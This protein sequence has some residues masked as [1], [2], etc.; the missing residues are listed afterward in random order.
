MEPT[1]SL[2]DLLETARLAFYWTSFDPDG[3]G[4][5]TITEFE[6]QLN[7]DLTTI[8]KEAANSEK[9]GDILTDVNERYI[10]NY[11]KYFTAWLRSE[12]NCASSA[13]A[14]PANFPVKRMEKHR[15][16]ADAKFQQFQDW[17]RRA[18]KAI[19]K[20]VKVVLTPGTELAKAEAKLK[21]KLQRQAMMK[22]ANKEIRKYK[23]AKE[24]PS[25]LVAALQALCVC[26]EEINELLGE[27]YQNRLG[28]ATWELSYINENIHR[29][30]KRVLYLRDK[31]ANATGATIQEYTTFKVVENRELDRVQFMFPGDPG[32][33]IRVLLRKKG[34]IYSPKNKANQR[35]L[36]PNA[37]RD[38][39]ELARKINAMLSPTV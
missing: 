11:R 22:A 10:M 29:L 32:D 4:E 30:E 8:A 13:V 35:K 33:D 12:S 18:L 38:A 31:V 6:Q 28:F 34:F 15:G 24:R 26:D 37:I 14:G 16:W 39:A 2:A 5:R 27:N 1:H 25:Q 17:R 21:A 36:T 23:D 19:T 20:G 7:I 9:S 3:R